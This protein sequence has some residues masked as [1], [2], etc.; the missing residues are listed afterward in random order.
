MLWPLL[1]LIPLNV[2]AIWLAVRG[3]MKPVLR[4]SGDIATRSGDNLAPLDISDQPGGAAADR[5]RG[6]ASGGALARG[7]RC[8][9]RLCGQQRP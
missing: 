7:A 6:R 8:R 3:A 4:L 9:A 2:L 1:A 5:G